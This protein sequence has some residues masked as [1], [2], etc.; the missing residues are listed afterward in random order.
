MDSNVAIQCL[1]GCIECNET[2]GCSLC[3]AGYSLN[4][5]TFEC[6]PC[7]GKCKTCYYNV[8]S[9]CLSC[10]QGYYYDELQCLSCNNNH[11]I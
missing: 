11:C 10:N 1:P 3:G 2:G 8:P 5:N 9:A 4:P 6:V 7:E